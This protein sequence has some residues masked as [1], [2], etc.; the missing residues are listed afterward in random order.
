[1]LKRTEIE[2]ALE[3]LAKHRPAFHSEADFQFALAWELRRR[4]PDL[5]VRLEYPVPLKDTR[6]EIDIW[7]PEARGPVAIELKYWTRR[8][9]LT[10]NGEPFVLK[11]RAFKNLYLYDFW[12]DVVRTESLI[13]EGPAEGGY[14][15]ALTNDRFYESAG[16]GTAAYEAFRMYE[17]REV[18]PETLAWT[19][20]PSPKAIR[21]R[22]APHQLRGRYFTCWQ[23]Y[24][25]N[26]KDTDS[27]FRYLLLDIEAGIAEANA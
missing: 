17:G 10:V 21:G 20:N 24:P 4:H 27:N 3:S 6:G 19:G 22:E 8:A 16:K 26:P 1:M 15:V 23:P 12:K 11:E 5:E 7:L 13:A 2:S 18:H 9:E 14:V 25:G